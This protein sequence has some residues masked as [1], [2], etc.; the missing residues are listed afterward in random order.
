[1]ILN[2]EQVRGRKFRTENKD[3]GRGTEITKKTKKA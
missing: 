1:M 3:Y 2:E